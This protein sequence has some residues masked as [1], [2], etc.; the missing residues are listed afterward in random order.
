MPVAKPVPAMKVEFGSGKGA[1]LASEPKLTL[2]RIAFDDSAAGV[3]SAGVVSAGVVCTD[4]VLVNVGRDDKVGIDEVKRG[5]WV[6]CPGS[7]SSVFKTPVVCGSTPVRAGREQTV[8]VSVIV[9][10]LILTV[11]D[12]L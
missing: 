9:I 6:G 7:P 10:V 5:V 2:L 1:T 3:V 11:R 8:A 4:C 12:T